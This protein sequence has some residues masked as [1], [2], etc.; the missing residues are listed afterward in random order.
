MGDLWNSLVDGMGAVLAFLYAIIPNYGFAIIGLTIAV[1]L[2][3]FPLTAKQARSMQKMQVIQPEIKKLQAR[4]KDD[5][6]KLNEEI[7]KFYKANKVNPMAGCLPLFAQMPIFFALFRVLRAPLTH[8]PVDSKLFEAFCGSATQATCKPKGLGFLGMDLSRA[9]NQPHGGFGDT[10]PYFVL[11][12]LVVLTGYLQFRQTQARQT[13]Q[14]PQ[15]AIMGKVFPV[16]FA[17]ISYTLPAG[18]VL[19]FLVSNGWQIGQQALIFGSILPTEPA[20]LAYPVG[21]DPKDKAGDQKD[22]AA[23]PDK[24]A[25]APDRR[26]LGAGGKSAAAGNGSG[27]PAPPG[28]PKDGLGRAQPQGSRPRP[29]KRRR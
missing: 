6:Q 15:M 1:R 25:K 23:P 3:L 28:S 5:R 27:Q 17:F 29:K 8:I 18:V 19:Y 14:N 10:L 13:T 2:L 24:P 21:E 12:G 16:T 26:A 4:Y 7:M 22:T 9:A 20:P 11:I